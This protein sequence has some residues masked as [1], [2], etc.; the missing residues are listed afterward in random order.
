MPTKIGVEIVSF[1]KL[2][3]VIFR[4]G[5]LIFLTLGLG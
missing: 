4:A 3:L 5:D 2:S 1:V